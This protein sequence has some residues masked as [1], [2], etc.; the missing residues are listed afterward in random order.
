MKATT[1]IFAAIFTLASANV[2]LAKDN[3]VI[4]TT[5]NKT[6]MLN[7]RNLAPLTPSEASFEEVISEMDFSNLAPE[8]PSEATFEDANFEMPIVT[9][10][11]PAVPA[12]ADFSDAS[13]ILMVNIN[14]LAP[15]T[16]MF[17]DFE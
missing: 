9:D 13:E 4:I 16:P 1:V 2:L 14:T 15:S 12:V 7:V 6:E 17:A 10:L 3:N 8:L 11:A 5:M